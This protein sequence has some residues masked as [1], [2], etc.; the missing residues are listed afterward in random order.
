MEGYSRVLTLVGHQGHNV[1]MLHKGCANIRLVSIPEP[2]IK[3]T[4][5]TTIFLDNFIQKWSLCLP[6]RL[7]KAAAGSSPWL[8]IRDT[9]VSLHKGCANIRLVSII[10]CW[11]RAL[12]LAVLLDIS[13]KVLKAVT[14]APKGTS[15]MHGCRT[16]STR[17]LS[18]CTAIHTAKYLYLLQGSQVIKTGFSL[19]EK[20]HKETLFSL[21]FYCTIW[22]LVFIR[23]CFEILLLIYNFLWNWNV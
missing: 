5:K 22:T 13:S 19:W 21:H 18:T 9:M 17:I 3:P 2:Q 8:A 16:F 20:L 1:V 10:I 23:D 7:L 6:G 12:M 4:H 14:L 15:P 11:S